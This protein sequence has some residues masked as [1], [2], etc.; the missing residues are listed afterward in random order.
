MSSRFRASRFDRRISPVSATLQ[1]RHG[2]RVDQAPADRGDRVV[3]GDEAQLAPG[4]ALAEYDQPGVDRPADRHD[5][6]NVARPQGQVA[7][8]P[9]DRGFPPAH[10]PLHRGVHPKDRAGPRHRHHRQRR[11]LESAV[12]A[13]L[14]H[15]L[16][17]PEVVGG[18]DPA[19][20]EPEVAMGPR[21][22][23]PRG[24]A[25]IGARPEPVQHRRNRMDL[26][27]EDR[28]EPGARLFPVARPRGGV[29]AGDAAV[30]AGHEDG[31]GVQLDEVGNDG[32][33]PPFPQ[34]GRGTS[35]PAGERQREKCPRR[36]GKCQRRRRAGCKA[37]HDGGEGRGRREAQG[38]RAHQRRRP[39]E[40]DARPRNFRHLR[41][42][43]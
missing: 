43:M 41:P 22:I 5:P 42:R 37:P 18:T 3:S 6:V 1:E 8:D 33:T 30:G 39:V 16:E 31:G 40:G 36:S 9:F 35:G 25:G 23:L 19:G 20:R 32:D 15:V 38:V 17:P 34:E 11:A 10:E 13:P 27:P 24:A 7:H 4:R 21:H 26:W 28:R 29:L 12:A 14:G 2:Q